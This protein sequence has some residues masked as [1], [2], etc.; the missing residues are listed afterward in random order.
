MDNI[1]LKKS[2]TTK[3]AIK[4]AT[5]NEGKVFVD[6]EEIDLMRIIDAHFADC[7]FD[8]NISE[9]SDEEM[10]IETVDVVDVDDVDYGETDEY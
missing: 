10:D 5:I 3:L 2:T 9:K 4:K 8:L 7:V 6:G 1:S